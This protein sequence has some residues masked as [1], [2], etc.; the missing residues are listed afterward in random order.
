MKRLVTVSVV[1]LLLGLWAGEVRARH[2]AYF[3]DAAAMTG[4]SGMALYRGGGAAWYNPAGLVGNRRSQVDLS[5]SVFILRFRDSSGLLETRTPGRVDVANLDTI[6]FDTIPSALLF[7]RRLGKR[8]HAAIGMFVTDQDAFQLRDVLEITDANGGMLSR[9]YQ[10]TT[11]TSK[12]QTYH[13]GV[14][15]S[16]ELHK[17]FRLGWGVFGVYSRFSYE[18][19]DLTA[20]HLEEQ[21]TG[22][23]QSPWLY[24]YDVSVNSTL[25]GLQLT[26]GMQ[27]EFAKR[28]FW[29]LMV[30]SP[31]LKLHY[32]NRFSTLVAVADS[33]PAPTDPAGIFVRERID[34]AMTELTTPMEL[35]AGFAY[36]AKEFFVGLE[37]ELLLPFR[38]FRT[39]VSTIDPQWNV[40]LGGRM[41]VAERVALGI[42]AFTER[43]LRKD[44][45]FVGDRRMDFYGAVFGVKWRKAHSVRGRTRDD[46]IVFTTTIAIRYAYGTGVMQGYVNDLVSGNGGEVER[47]HH[48]HEFALYLGSSLYF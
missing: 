35:V 11:I 5:A 24:I 9:Y 18:F 22:N 21:S 25:W 33:A 19:R 23:L 47:L 6:T 32:A 37:G 2:T 12:L 46:A 15:L 20:S 10:R 36:K 44:L 42:G 1:A 4:S 13:F 28:W 34:G 26:M 16:W 45:F 31:T 30:R 17:R 29:G 7:K 41:Y 43:S 39:Y 8:V 38:N 48:V 40:R 14:M 3:G 27:W